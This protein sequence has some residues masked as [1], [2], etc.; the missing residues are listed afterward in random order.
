MKKQSLIIIITNLAI[1]GFLALT[2]VVLLS[3]SNNTQQQNEVRTQASNK[4]NTTPTPNEDPVKFERENL[5]AKIEEYT[6]EL[7][8]VG[9]TS[10][11]QDF[12][13]FLASDFE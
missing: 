12:P 10:E 4:N 13:G 2:A 8:T 6:Q 9:Q 1:V 3:K 5:T 11:D 7:N